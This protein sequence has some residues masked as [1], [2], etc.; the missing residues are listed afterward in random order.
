MNAGDRAVAGL[1]SRG[2]RGEGEEVKESE[3]DLQGMA[4]GDVGEVR[5]VY[6][7]KILLSSPYV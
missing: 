4:D 7:I 5:N 1:H 3:M 2:G 6:I